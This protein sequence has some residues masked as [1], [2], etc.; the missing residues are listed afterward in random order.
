VTTSLNEVKDRLTT[1]EQRQFQREENR[2]TQR[3][4]V[5]TVLGFLGFVVALA[6]GL[7]VILRG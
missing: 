4:D 6:V 3:L 5:G 1:I 2:T 7:A